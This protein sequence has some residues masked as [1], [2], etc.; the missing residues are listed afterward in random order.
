MQRKK[1]NN[2][3]KAVK[4]VVDY[5][6]NQDRVSESDSFDDKTDLTVQKEKV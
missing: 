6:L 3:I 4:I 2:V 5:F 1:I